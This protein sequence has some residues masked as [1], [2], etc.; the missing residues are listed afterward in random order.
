MTKFVVY[1]HTSPSGKV[2]IGITSQKPESRWRQGKGYIKNKYF[3][4]AISKYGWDAFEH[5]ILKDNLPEQC[6]KTWEKIL[7]AKYQ[8]TNPKKG[9]NFSSGGEGA[10]G[11]YG[12]EHPLYG[13]RLS[14]EHRKKLSDSHKGNKPSKDDLQKRSASMKGKNTKSICKYDLNHNLIETFTSIKEAANSVNGC[15]KH[16][17]RDISKGTYKGYIWEYEAVA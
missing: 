15:Y 12:K 7:I 13:R 9:Y 16:F 5:T 10:F 3:Y 6:A 11:R 2:Y 14:D 1:K 17:K 8:S 4:A